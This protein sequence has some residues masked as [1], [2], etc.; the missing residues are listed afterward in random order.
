M[1]IAR[2]RLILRLRCPLLLAA[3]IATICPLPAKNLPDPKAGCRLVVPDDWSVLNPA[4]S[5]GYAIQAVKA[6]RSKA[7]LLFVQPVSST[8]SIDDNSDIIRGFEDGYQKSGGK[9]VGRDRQKLH[10][11][12]FYVLTGAQDTG[13]G[14]LHTCAWVTVVA[15]HM[16]QVCLYDLGGDPAKDSELSTAINSFSI[17]PK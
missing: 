17:S 9:I 4:A 13:K 3:L 5:G 6:D 11:I 7:V 16:Y 1:T 12:T 8:A 14:V 2:F 10:D 15:G